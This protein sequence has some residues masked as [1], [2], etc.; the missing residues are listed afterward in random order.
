MVIP[1][2]AMVAIG[3]LV[4][5]VA[6]AGTGALY[7]AVAGIAEVLLSSMS[8]KA[9]KAGRS[10]APYTFA[11]GV[12]AA[13]VGRVAFE[14]WRQGSSKFAT[15]SLLGLSAAAG[16]FLFY[17]LI[18]GGNPPKKTAPGADAGAKTE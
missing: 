11:S 16:T 4:A 12:I 18:A 2:G 10:S 5:A 8:L 17:N 1:Y 3:G 9:W 13:V 7:I 15:G 14:A 6:G